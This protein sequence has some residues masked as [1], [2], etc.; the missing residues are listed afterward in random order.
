MEKVEMTHKMVR[1]LFWYDYKIGDLFWRSPGQ[2]KAM[3]KPAGGIIGNGYK[4]ILIGE[5]S[6][7]TH[8]LIWLYHNGY[9]PENEID[10]IDRNPLNNRIENLREVTRQCNMRNVKIA[11]NNRSSVTGVSW[12][13]RIKKW[14]AQIMINKKQIHLGNFTR[15]IDAV[16]A[17]YT[18][19]CEVDWELCGNISSAHKY[20]Q[21]NYETS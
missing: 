12:T 13:K 16:K 18:K 15:F 17:R 5:T 21:E 6:Y 14:H 4:R 10:H 20:I 8:R 9:F 11:K 7:Y 2:H 19:E 1:K 3:D